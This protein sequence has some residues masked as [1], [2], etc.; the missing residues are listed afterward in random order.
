MTQP[1]VQQMPSAAQPLFLLA[2]DQRD[3]F[4]KTLYGITGTP[5]ASGLA[6]MRDGKSLI[7]EA[8]RELPAS[9]AGPGRMGILVDEQL[10][11]DVARAAKAGGFV[12]A[13]PV[14]VS[15]APRLAFEYG[16]DFPE[17]IEAFD[18][19]WVKVLVR[20]NPADPEE[21]RHAQTGT[22]RQL[23]D[24][25]AGQRRRWLLELLV[26]ATREQ[27]A[28]SED[29]A[30]YDAKERPGLTAEVIAELTKG[31][32]RPDVWKLE[33][34]ETTEGA[35][36][37][38]DA[39]KH[40]TDSGSDC[41]VL[42]RNAPMHQVDHW[43]DVAAP[44]PGYVGFAIGRSNW[45]QPLADYLAGRADREAVQERIR[46]NYEHFIA[47]YLAADTAPGNAREPSRDEAFSYDHPRLTPDREAIIR[48]ATTGAQPRGTMLPAW[49]AQSLLAEV[50]ALRAGH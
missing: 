23:S 20:Y 42:G 35:E 13:M 28:A 17:H 19:D 7:F 14:E 2:M 31:G 47:R 11:A 40:S 18:P 16:D 21:L 26:P 10:G 34:Y 24:W 49:M 12:L 36:V 22:L 33:G 48:R 8:V 9:V 25:T 43:L 41:I 15:G 50:D 27:L 38:L 32:V 46:G 6:R 39:I 37:V 44:L 45:E 4:A 29:Q 3:S 5:D 30:L 1:R